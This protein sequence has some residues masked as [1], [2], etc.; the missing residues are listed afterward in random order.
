MIEERCVIHNKVMKDKKT[1]TIGS[2]NNFQVG[3]KVDYSDIGEPNPNPN[4]NQ[5]LFK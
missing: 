3:C 1:M 2:Y 4:L 5:Y